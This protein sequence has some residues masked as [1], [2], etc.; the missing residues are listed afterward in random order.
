MGFR[1]DSSRALIVLAL[2]GG[3][4][5]DD[6]EG[7][8]PGDCAPAD[9]DCSAGGS[10]G[11]SGGTAAGSSNGGNVSGTGGS[12]VSGGASGGSGGQRCTGTPASDCTAADCDTL[13]G[14]NATTQ[15][16]CMG[17]ASSCSSFDGDPD[18]CRTQAGCA[19]RP[20]GNCYSPY[21]SC[22]SIDS[23]DECDFV[24]GCQFSYE[25][26]ECVGT[27]TNCA[28]ITEQGACDQATACLWEPVE[29]RYC[30]GVATSC[31]SMPASTCDQQEGCSAS[32]ASCTGT[33]TPCSELTAADCK[34]QPG[35]RLQG[36]GMGGAGGAGPIVQG[37]DLV[38]EKLIAVQTVIDGEEA[39][40]FQLTVMNRGSVKAAAHGSKVV[41]STDTELG[42]ADD[43]TLWPLSV[44]FELSAFGE[45]LATWGPDY[46][47]MTALAD[48]VPSSGYYY[49]GAIADSEAQIDETEED[50]NTAISSRIFFGTPSYDFE[51]VDV[52]YDATSPIAPGSAL[53][54]SVTV[55]NSSNIEI[56]ALPLEVFVS[57]DTSLDA[58]DL[59][60]C[61]TTAQVNLDVGAEA[62]IP[63]SCT[64]PRLRGNFYV[65]AVLNPTDAVVESNTANNAAVATGA[66]TFAAPSPDLVMSNVGRDVANVGWKG[67]V[68]FSGTVQNTGIDPAGT[69]RVGF[70][71]STDAVFQ[72]GDTLVCS[73]TV[74]GP[75]AAAASVPV[76]KP[77]TLP[78]EVTGT[79][80][81]IAVADSLDA[82]FETNETNNASTGAAQLNVFPP[83]WD[84]VAGAFSDDGGTPL[85][86]GQSVAFQL[87]VTN[88]GTDDIPDFELSVR[89]SSDNAITSSD[90]LVCTRTLGGIPAQT[91]KGYTF[92]CD[93]P[94]VPEA[95]Y[96]TGVIVDSAADFAE[97]DETNNTNVDTVPRP[98]GP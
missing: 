81:V 77:C 74:P 21:T 93:V 60:T 73:E 5:G 32:A 72:A 96:Y 67:D 63:L 39:L 52:S 16:S 61:T 66:L 89:L 75:I 17:S 64:A 40:Q 20:A 35:C 54:V 80:Y 36:Q 31:E 69:L 48:E 41:F 30:N 70:Y 78:E 76:S 65:G 53:P 22:S 88:S 24:S 10:A 6:G 82:I 90:T 2:L 7:R 94:P 33:P 45:D 14:C 71:V 56:T 1:L 12:A 97:S 57:S 86:I 25:S 11:S 95:Q 19:A 3:C 28:L 44:D 50:N 26:Y 42:N 27:L 4:G 23:M 43:V 55:K 84:L 46:F 85:T 37:P 91:Q 9:G 87:V 38:I 34:S 62:V 18:S 51:I 15:G 8:P 83:N 29:V 49:I 13:L 58:G 47:A 68:T 98:V 59:R 92:S 79:R